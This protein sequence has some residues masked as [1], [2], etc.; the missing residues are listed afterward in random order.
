[1]SPSPPDDSG[2]VADAPQHS[3]D[4]SLL[5]KVPITLFMR[6]NLG[7]EP[8][9]PLTPEVLEGLPLPDEIWGG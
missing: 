4:A 5:G 7:I 9:N 1:M 8:V 3:T 6:E 2:R